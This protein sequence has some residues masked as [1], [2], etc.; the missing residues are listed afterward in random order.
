M[1]HASCVKTIFDVNIQKRNKNLQ[2]VVAELHAS[3]NASLLAFKVSPM[4]CRVSGAL[5]QMSQTLLESPIQDCTL[6]GSLVTNLNV[7]R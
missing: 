6:K 4:V 3:Q 5:L 2:L 1:H 7:T